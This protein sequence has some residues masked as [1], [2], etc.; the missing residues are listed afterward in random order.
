MLDG[1]S[2]LEPFVPPIAD[3]RRQYGP[4]LSWASLLLLFA[5]PLSSWVWKAGETLAGAVIRS[6]WRL[7]GA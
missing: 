3:L 2:V 4:T 6:A 1:W 5:T 7:L